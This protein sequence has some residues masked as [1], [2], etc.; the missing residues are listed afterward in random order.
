MGPLQVSTPI[1]PAEWHGREGRDSE[2]TC[3]ASGDAVQP[4]AEALS[5]EHDCETGRYTQMLWMGLRTKTAYLP[6]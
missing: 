1:P 2:H 6:G 3:E 4:P 5:L